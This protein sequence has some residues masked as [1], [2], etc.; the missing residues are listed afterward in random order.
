M[1]PSK[2]AKL[3]NLL[4]TMKGGKTPVVDLAMASSYKTK[5][6]H[7]NRAVAQLL[8]MKLSEASSF[9]NLQTTLANLKTGKSPPQET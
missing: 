1:N 7:E 6:N 3:R 8:I 2:A 9:T 5:T 4:T